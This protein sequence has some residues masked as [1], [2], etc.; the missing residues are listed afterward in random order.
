ML[1]LCGNVLPA[2]W[3]NNSMWCVVIKNWVLAVSMGNEKKKKILK[4]CTVTVPS[5]I[6]GTWEHN[7]TVVNSSDCL[8]RVY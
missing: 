2:V 4:V 1:F 7:V 8:V 5:V 3:L 6:C